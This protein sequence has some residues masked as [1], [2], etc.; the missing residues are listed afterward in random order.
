MTTFSFEFFPPA[1]EQGRDNLL[2]VAKELSVHEPAFV[3]VTY[4]AGGSTRERTIDAVRTLGQHVSAPVAAH[5]TTVAAD[6]AGTA[7]AASSKTFWL[8]RH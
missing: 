2:A 3:S 1:T 6:A 7:A 8:M 4:G 5:L